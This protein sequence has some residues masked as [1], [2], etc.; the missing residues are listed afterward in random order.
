MKEQ[1]MG[2]ADVVTPLGRWPRGGRSW[3]G[4]GKVAMAGAWWYPW[5]PSSS[6]SLRTPQSRGVHQE[7]H[8]HEA[9]LKPREV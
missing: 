8:G 1:E 5:I 2:E 4:R 3:G 7:C 9:M 6:Y